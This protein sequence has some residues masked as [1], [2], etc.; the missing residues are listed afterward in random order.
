[1]NNPPNHPTFVNSVLSPCL[2]VLSSLLRDGM[3]MSR[4]IWHARL[5]NGFGAGQLIARLHPI[6]TVLEAVPS[7][8]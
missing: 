5:S 2:T 4:V 6:G 7:L 3:F 8:P 1:M